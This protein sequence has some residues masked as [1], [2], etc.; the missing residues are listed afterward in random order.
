MKP[1]VIRLFNVYSDRYGTNYAGNVWSRHGT[2]P[3]ILT[4]GGG[5]RQPM[6]IEIYEIQT[7]EDRSLYTPH[8]ESAHK[9]CGL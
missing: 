8:M 7:E 1:R 4:M 5:N 3:A 2:S 6:I 9:G